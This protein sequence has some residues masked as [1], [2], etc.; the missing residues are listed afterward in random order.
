MLLGASAFAAGPCE[1]ADHR[2]FDFWVGEWNVY[3]KGGKLVGENSITREFNGCLI[4]EHYSTPGG[5]S[6][7]SLNAY[8]RGRKVWTQTWVDSGGLVLKLEGGLEGDSMVLEGKTVNRQ[9]R[10]ISHRITWTPGEDGEVRQHWQSSAA[11]GEW[12]TLFDG[13]YRRK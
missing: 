1:T 3:G 13:T 4:H 7:E 12:K 8:D 10:E 9:A 11:G 2:A 5:Y 6:G